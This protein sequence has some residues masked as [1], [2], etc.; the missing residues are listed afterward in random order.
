MQFSTT[1]SAAAVNTLNNTYAAATPLYPQ[2]V[3]A[4]LADTPQPVR[5]SSIDFIQAKAAS[6]EL[7]PAA[8]DQISELL[9]ER[10][11]LTEAQDDDFKILDLTEIVHTAAHASELMGALLMTV[12]AISLVVGGV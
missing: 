7:V 4:Q 5:M 11:H 6:A 9:R 1:A 2:P 8:I 12:A 10:H 3:A